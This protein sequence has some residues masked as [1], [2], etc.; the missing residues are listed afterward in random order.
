MRAIVPLL[1]GRPLFMP[2]DVEQIKVPNAVVKLAE[3]RTAGLVCAAIH[4]PDALRV[5]ICSAYL[6]GLEDGYAAATRGASDAR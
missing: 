5:M 2:D 4:W 6:Q 3:R 1:S